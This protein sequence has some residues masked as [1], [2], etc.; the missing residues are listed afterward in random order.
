M[1]S[2]ETRR[3]EIQMF[4]RAVELDPSFALA[5]AQLSRAHSWMVNLGFD[6]MAKGYILRRMGAWEE[7][8][9]YVLEALELSPRDANLMG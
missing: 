6:R 7:S 1:Y 3:L 9:N 5:Y 8:R 4:E 2:I